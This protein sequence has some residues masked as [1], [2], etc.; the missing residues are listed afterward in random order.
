MAHSSEKLSSTR[1]FYWPILCFVGSFKDYEDRRMEILF[2]L[3][4]CRRETFEKKKLYYAN[5][6]PLLNILNSK[7]LPSAVE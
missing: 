7:I 5:F 2:L 1:G 6:Y 4:N 3:L